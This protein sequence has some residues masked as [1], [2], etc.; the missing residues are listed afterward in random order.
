MEK[1]Q[2]FVKWM[3]FEPTET[4]YP[5]EKSNEPN[6]P[7]ENVHFVKGINFVSFEEKNRNKM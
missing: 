1:F 4:H 3:V 2:Q 5:S 6:G 7:V